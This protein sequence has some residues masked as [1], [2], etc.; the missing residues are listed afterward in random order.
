MRSD[1]SLELSD[2]YRSDSE[3]NAREE[4][5]DELSSYFN[6]HMVNSPS[7][8][9]DSERQSRSDR[10]SVFG[11]KR[12]PP[13]PPP[14]SPSSSAF[15]SG[16]P[17]APN[18]ADSPMIKPTNRR[19][20]RQSLAMNAN[21]RNNKQDNNNNLNINS[22]LRSNTSPTAEIR[23]MHKLRAASFGSSSESGTEG[24][25]RTP[26]PPNR[27]TNNVKNH[28]E[29]KNNNTYDV[30]SIANTVIISSA[31]TAT[32]N[33]SSVSTP[34]QINASSTY[35]RPQP[36]ENDIDYSLNGTPALSSTTNNNSS[37]SSG[38]NS[39]SSSI[40]NMPIA[41]DGDDD[42]EQSEEEDDDDG[43]DDEFDDDGNQVKVEGEYILS[44]YENFRLANIARNEAKLLALGLLSGGG[45]INGLKITKKTSQ[46][47]KVV[48][49]TK[50]E[51]R[52]RISKRQKSRPAAS[53]EGFVSTDSK[54]FA[55]SVKRTR[56]TTTNHSLED[57]AKGEEG[58]LF[59]L[60][61][62]E[63]D[64]TDPK[65][66]TLENASSMVS[67]IVTPIITPP[68]GSETVIQEILS[69]T[70]VGDQFLLRKKGT[71]ITAY[72]LLQRLHQDD[73]QLLN[74]SLSGAPT[75]NLTINAL[76]LKDDLTK[77]GPSVYIHEVAIKREKTGE[78]FKALGSKK[79]SSASRSNKL[80]RMEQ[81]AESMEDS[82]T[83][84]FPY[85]GEVCAIDK[86][87]EM[88]RKEHVEGNSGAT[89]FNFVSGNSITTSKMFWASPRRHQSIERG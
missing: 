89:L 18:V 82:E 63:D 9:S 29:I 74:K 5:S 34:V 17:P 85:V 83:V 15:D 16:L 11:N 84:Y 32:T 46:K 67:K 26:P 78:F 33:N 8:A 57:N 21:T 37:L 3:D 20:T 28:V 25:S 80:F 81:S 87:A 39:S 86:S 68:N 69:K 10:Q 31:T 45:Y 27:N 64:Q 41:N 62:A 73:L 13:P 60:I 72:L 54:E 14:S 1:S 47:R 65:S 35:R 66:R 2:G 75:P 61:M 58:E 38:G 50:L 7:M 44:E 43:D 79:D 24:G 52:P 53:L 51:V 55:E 48:N 23:K 19:L 40:N 6:D 4:G 36:F 88:R 59:S 77:L 22:T 12:V 56:Q 76:H 49:I 42:D 71:Y 70:Q 30:N